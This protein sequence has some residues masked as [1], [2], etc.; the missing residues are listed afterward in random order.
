MVHVD[1][2][3]PW[4]LEP[5]IRPAAFPLAYDYMIIDGAFVTLRRMLLFCVLLV[6]VPVLL[7]CSFQFLD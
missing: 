1:K 4:P 5:N 3:H 7:L 2:V 6:L